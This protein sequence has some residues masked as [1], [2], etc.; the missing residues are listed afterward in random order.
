VIAIVGVAFVEEQA[1]KIPLIAAT[2]TTRDHVGFTRALRE[3]TSLRGVA[4]IDVPH[5]RLVA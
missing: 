3:R 1:A 5:P 2:K 4:P